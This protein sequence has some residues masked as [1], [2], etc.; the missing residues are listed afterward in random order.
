MFGVPAACWVLCRT[1]QEKEGPRFQWVLNNSTFLVI[2]KKYHLIAPL[3]V[4][5]FSKILR[6]MGV[7]YG[8]RR[9]L[10][11]IASTQFIPGI[12]GAL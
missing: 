11:S 12:P 10:K 9:I 8:K 2:S 1:K 3:E 6:P 5:G 4:I 7:V